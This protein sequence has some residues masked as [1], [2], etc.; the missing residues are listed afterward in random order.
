MT[1]SLVSSVA[2]SLV[3]PFQTLDTE[4]GEIQDKYLYIDG[5]SKQYR[6]DAK[7]G[8]FSVHY[9]ENNVEKMGT[10]LSFQ[11]IA[12]RIFTDDIL[13]QGLK[14]WA[15]LF[16]VDDF[17]CVSCVLFHNFSVANL[18]QL[19]TPLVYNRIKLNEMVLS[20]NSDKENTKVQPKGTYY[21]TSFT[22]QLA[23]KDRTQ[24]MTEYVKTVNLYRRDTQT[25]KVQTQVARHVF[26]P[27]VDSLV[28][29]ELAAYDIDADAESVAD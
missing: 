1:T 4:L 3:G 18:E 17:D 12:W 23:D 22:Y 14:K 20:V 7:E 8:K 28:N 11:P 27:F 9:D 29:P 15:E 26:N 21:I 5:S 16:F 2:G 10:S 24:E 19:I 13:A 6:F 25:D